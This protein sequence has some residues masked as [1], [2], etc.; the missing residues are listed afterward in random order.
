[1]KVKMIKDDREG[2]GDN[3]A[4]NSNTSSRGIAI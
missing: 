3:F 2:A 4:N 1:M